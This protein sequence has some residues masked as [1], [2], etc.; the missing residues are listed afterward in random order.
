MVEGRERLKLAY[1]GQLFD[2]EL[3]AMLATDPRPQLEA[4]PMTPVGAMSP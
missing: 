3:H 2:V 4:V 1:D